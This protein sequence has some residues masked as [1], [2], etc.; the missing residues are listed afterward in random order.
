MSRFP[1]KTMVYRRFWTVN[2]YNKNSSI[3][4]LKVY[5]TWFVNSQFIGGKPPRPPALVQHTAR[6]TKSLESVALGNCSVISNGR[7]GH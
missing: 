5:A 3:G 2:N 1:E 6:T 7:G 4:M